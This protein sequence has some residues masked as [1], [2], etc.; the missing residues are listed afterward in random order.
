MD[1]TESFLKV[2]NTFPE[3]KE[4][5]E[6][7]KNNSKGNIWLIG[8]F[9]CRSIIQDLYGIQMS[10]DVDFDFIV[11]EPK[12]VQIPEN[13]EMRMNSY[14]NPKFIGPEY[15]IDFVPLN[16]IH[17]ILRRNLEPTIENF[18]TGAPLNVQSIVYDVR[19]NKVIGDIGIKSIQ[20]K[21]VAV[22][23]P[24]QAKHRALKKG[25]TVEELVKDIADQFK[26]RPL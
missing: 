2:A 14:G 10:Q 1:Y 22:N 23:D 21:I 25:V 16:N 17:S 8:G 6:I 15:E 5:V 24:E 18:L 12:E 9:V 13:W 3:F 26:F 20:D 4:A 11:E 7:V 19:S